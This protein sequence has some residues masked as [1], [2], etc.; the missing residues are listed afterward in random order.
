MSRDGEAVLG[1][2]AAWTDTEPSG[3]ALL[4]RRNGAWTC[5]RVAPGYDAF[6]S[7]SL[8]WSAPV[9][10]APVNAGAVLQACRVLLDGT[11]PA[12][13]AADMPLAETPVTCR[14]AC[15][16][17]V[18]SLFGHRK[19]AVHSPTPL[20]PG[21]TSRRLH[22]GFAKHGYKLATSAGDHRP[23]LIEVYPHV[24]LLGLT[25]RGERL[26]YKAG[27]STT[28]W[29]DKPAP[30]RKALLVKEWSGIL[31]K[32][33]KRVSGIRLELPP[34]PERCTFGHLKRYEDALDGLVC[35]WVAAL[36]LDGLAAPLGET[37]AA[38]WVPQSS[39][40][41]AGRSYAT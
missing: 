15:D 1:I 14:R 39:M 23:A 12:A 35:A 38:I 10:G 34:A 7:P 24:A 36:Y 37:G 6:C 33:S 32:L 25:G 5:L 30:E 18:S 3:V 13:I 16:D 29:P 26:P 27:K 19:C 8:D 40:R 22:E 21:A 20:R 2:D 11:L 41:F 28:Y 9:T 17:E 4:A 31:G